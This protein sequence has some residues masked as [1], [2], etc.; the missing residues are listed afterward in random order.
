MMEALNYSSNVPS[1]T[2][3]H[4]KIKEVA[5][6]TQEDNFLSTMKNLFTEYHR[7]AMFEGFFLTF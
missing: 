1:Y 4:H 3:S 7:S 6:K 5:S 2:I